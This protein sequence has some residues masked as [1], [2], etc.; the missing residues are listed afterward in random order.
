VQYSRYARRTAVQFPQL[1]GGFLFSKATDLLFSM[2]SVGFLS[3]V[4]GRGER[5]TIQC[6]WKKLMEPHLHGRSSVVSNL[7]NTYKILSNILLSRLTPY[8]EEIIGDHQCGFRRIRS[9]TDLIMCISQILKK[10]GIQR[11]NASAL[12]K[13]QEI[14]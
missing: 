5:L 12:Y 10:M 1:E 3:R 9:T 14:L 2:H 13:P 8:A 7:P 4:C 6:R 11:N